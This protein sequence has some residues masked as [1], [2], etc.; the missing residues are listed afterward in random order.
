MKGRIAYLHIALSLILILFSVKCAYYFQDQETDDS[1]KGMPQ[2]IGMMDGCENSVSNFEYFPKFFFWLYYGERKAI[3]NFDKREDIYLKIYDD[4]SG[5]ILFEFQG[6]IDSSHFHLELPEKIDTYNKRDVLVKIGGSTYHSEIMPNNPRPS[7]CASTSG[8]GGGG[9]EIKIFTWEGKFIRTIW[10][11]ETSSVNP[12][13]VYWDGKDNNA[14]MVS[15]KRKYIAIWFE[16]G[17]PIR[18]RV[19]LLTK[20][21]I[22]MNIS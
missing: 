6:I 2:W 15:Q 5:E 4:T 16:D 17:K 10:S 3:F 14:V 7:P 22:M 12:N 13:R 9:D 21:Q 11:R 18:A 1:K 8:F 19:I 20:P